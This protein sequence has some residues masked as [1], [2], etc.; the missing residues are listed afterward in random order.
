MLLA[1]EKGQLFTGYLP[2][3]LAYRITRATAEQVMRSSRT[4]S[5]MATKRQDF[6]PDFVDFSTISI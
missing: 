1:G 2:L 6:F 4:A 3:L 5:P